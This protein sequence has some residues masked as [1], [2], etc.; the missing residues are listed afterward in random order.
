M[1]GRGGFPLATGGFHPGHPGH[2]P[3]L[4]VVFKKPADTKKLAPS[5]SIGFQ[6]KPGEFGK[7]Q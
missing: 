1:F 6:K 3:H 5:D 2:G 4:G 7:I